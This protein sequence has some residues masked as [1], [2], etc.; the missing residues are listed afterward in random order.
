[1]AT[2]V[3]ALSTAAGSAW[4]APVLPTGGV[5][6]AGSASISST[7]S[8]LTVNQT[9]AKGVISWQGF[10][11]GQGGA[12]RINNGSG[13]T[14]NRVTG[15][16][17]SSIDGLLSA[18]GSVY[19]I[20]PNGIIIGKTGVVNTGGSFVASTLDV[21]NSSFLAGGPLGFTG[22]STA[23]VVNLG[24][25]G[26]LGG[27]IALI[28]TTVTNSGALT[29]ANGTVGLAAGS[30]VTL[31]DSANDD[32]GLLSVQLGG[33][34]SSVTTS[35]LIQ[36]AAAELRAQQGNIFALAGNTG[37]AIEATG[38]DGKGGRI[39]LVSQGGTASIAGTLDAQGAGAK[40][41]QIE[42]SG[43]TLDIGQ[44]S[45]NTH[46]GTWL[47]DPSDIT[48]T[49]AN[50]GTLEASLAT[51][52]VVEDTSTGSGGSGNITV[53]ALITWSSGFG[54]TLNAVGALAINAPITVAGAGQLTLNFN[55]AASATDGLSFGL[56][57]AGFAGSV[58]YAVGTG[59]GVSG[60]ALTINGQAYN[61][62]Y[63]M[64]DLAGISGAYAPAGNTTAYALA[65]PLTST[66]TYTSAVVSNFG[67]TLEGLGQTITGL[68]IVTSNTNAG[69][70]Q[71]LTG[72]GLVRDLGLVGGEVSGAVTV[73]ELV[74][75][76]NGT[77]ETSYATGAVSGA[78]NVGGLVGFQEGT[79]KTSYATGAVSGGSTVGGLLGINDAG[80]V[81]ASYATGAVSG[82]SSVGGLIGENGL[83]SVTASYAT[84]AVSGSDSVGG[85]IGSGLGDL[86]STSFAT[87]AVSGASNVGGLIG[88]DDGG[89]VSSSYWDTQTT[90]QSASADGGTGLTTA[91]FQSNSGGY[92]STLGAAFGGGTGGFF[93]YLAT[94]FPNGVQAVAGTL[95]AAPASQVGLYSGG[96]LLGQGTTSVGADGSY[97][98]AVPAGTFSTAGPNRVGDSLALPTTAGNGVTVA[99]VSALSYT[100]AAPVSG[101]I[102]L[103]PAFSAGTVR[104]TTGDS[105]YGQLQTDL[106]ITFGAGAMATLQT[107]LANAPVTVTS[108]HASGFTV[109]QSL[110]LANSL[111][112]ATTATGAPITV[113]APIT[114]TGSNSLTL[115]AADALNIDARINVTGG[116]Q[117]VLGFSTSPT[118]N[119]TGA[120]TGGLSF[121]LT[122]AGFTGSL[123]YAV[124]TGEGVSGQALT[125]NS[126]AYNLVYSMTDLAGIGG[127]YAPAGNTTAYAL[128]TPLTSTTTFT[129]PVVSSFSGKLEGL[130]QTITGL[131]INSGD[132]DVGLIGTVNS[133]GL[134]RDLGLVGGGVS[135]DV[136]VGALIGANAGT[137]ETSYATGTVS[138]TGDLGGLVGENLG[139]VSTSYATGAVSGSVGMGGLIGINGGPV[140]TSYATGAISGTETVGGLIGANVASGTVS[141]SYATGAV[142]GANFLGGLVGANQGAVLTSYATGPVSE[143]GNLGN[144][145][146]LVGD[147]GGTVS[148]SY[149]DTQ[150]TGQSASPEGGTGL[151]TAQFKSNSGS[152]MSNL[153]AAF[154]GG[155]GGLFPYL[156]AFFP[157][158][159]QAVAG[160]LS[161]AAASQVG[162]YSGGVLLG[163]GTT[164][165]GADGSYYL[166]VP[167]GTFSTAGPNR[168]GDSL[169]P[170][171]T[172]GNG[173]TVAAVSAL[174]YTDAATVSGGVLTL[175]AFTAGTVSETTGDASYSALQTD[176]AATFGAGALSTLQTALANTPV[177]LTSTNTG[178]F[179][180]DQ[181]VS[182]GGGFSLTA[183]GPLTLAAAGSIAAGSGADISL[184]TPGSFVNQ[185]GAAALTTSGGGNWL[186]YSANP[187]GDT[188]DGLNSNNTAVWNTAAGAP[189]TASGDRYVFALAPTLTLTATSDSK[190]YGQDDSADLQSHYT[191]TGLEPGVSGAYLG[192]T[193][194][195]VYS[196][197]PAISSTGSGQTAS[198]A[199]G[200]YAIVA[201]AG[202][203]AVQD[204]YALSIAAG[205]HL[206]VNPAPLTI[207]ADSGSV[208]YGSSRL[209]TLGASYIGLVAG[210]TPSKFIADLFVTILAGAYN[211]RA[212]SGSDV[213]SY[214]VVPDGGANSNYAIS[215]RF[216]SLTVT[217]AALTI[218]A[219]SSS[220]T[221]GASSLPVLGVS[222]SGLANGDTASS[223]ATAPTVATTATAYNG[224]AGSG[225]NAGR[226]AIT[227]SGAVDSN[228]TISYTPGSLT[229]NP[230]A[231]T[232][233]ANNASTTY[234][235]STLP[236]L[237]AS[238]T[239]LANGDTA[240]NLST[241][242]SLATTA[243]AYNG[244]AGSGSNAG[245]YAVT[246]SGA[247]DS[248]YAISYTPGSLTVNPAAL[249]IAANNASTTYGASTLPALSASYTG[250]AN[251][252]TPSNLSTAP[253]LATTATAY[254]GTAGSGSNAGTY[255]VTASGA[256]D[257]NYAISYTP[258]ALTV[259][260][261]SIT[262]AALGGIST[263]GASPANPGLSV[264]GL[265]NGDTTTALGGLSNSFGITSS[266]PAGAYVLTVLGALTDPNYTV[267]STSPGAW[268]VSAAAA[269]VGPI[270]TLTTV[271]G[272]LPETGGFTTLNG[273]VPGVTPQIG[274]LRLI[275]LAQTPDQTAP[276]C[277]SSSVGCP[278]APYPTN[279]QVGPGIRFVA[280]K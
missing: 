254:N 9:S 222:Y 194:A 67:G 245:T 44:A 41:G 81:S 40:P 20:N 157:N 169:A 154:G 118:S 103:L 161:A 200:P 59:E 37:G 246:A 175:P 95:S 52:N 144:L 83:G 193:A 125:I 139:A 110:T 104:E 135:G 131:T 32:G 189:V 237:S 190:T 195:A 160:T 106:A 204:G 77:V 2:S 134:V 152:Y 107:A 122:S 167:A 224:T 253:N 269:S 230:A 14:L 3:L 256:V 63:S 199:G 185:A 162:L 54:L 259:N 27:N 156:T 130:G 262:V 268:T 206:T 10:S 218:A 123:S 210:D 55:T 255:A 208:T 105:S 23:S 183:A 244:T 48:I 273:L 172:A 239:G 72:G 176:L 213:G 13:A 140:S 97:Y 272:V 7:A 276:A 198:V 108:A 136:G 29:A 184:S 264:A 101:G 223:L 66:T 102:L 220:M 209:P 61:L 166:A 34:A 159:V 145:G 90:G 15:A 263:S 120:Q 226:Y 164:S 94:F 279:L 228:Y 217:P 240:S 76:N 86:V 5:V 42:T 65:T 133:G 35:G 235:A 85:L 4:S 16:S 1:M 242:P 109:D 258:G 126:Q 25:V 197:A 24:K 236:A 99:A 87:G 178:G 84:G 174:S 71:E 129:D 46:G 211:G 117:V 80:S 196:G 265:Q 146:G 111:T 26:A 148:T 62:V 249:T 227:A 153:G 137:A 247:V 17:V 60:Q 127:A 28:A 45:V 114:L 143:S 64:A 78:S 132:D 82:G 119:T 47:L 207:T 241:A 171:T 39:W 267:A 11:I 277:A 36:A 219:S 261:A 280:S 177:V 53:N 21:A 275:S 18:T 49:S 163:Q 98:L 79:I 30:S 203:L 229:V 124:G 165:V 22:S 215:Y 56:T 149:W 205:G 141:T 231:L 225:S 214:T 173:V 12:V 93:P 6:T 192:D 278:G 202:T 221:Y 51:G 147:A 73:G 112:I 238:Y 188:F 270:P 232:I 170:P 248:N 251:G 128:A 257:S 180:V 8:T 121:G 252:D 57:S 74:A 88:A 70:I 31:T 33:P 43:Q 181:A 75:G 155:T 100:D 186:V 250:L 138:G 19:L 187:T 113:S 91:Q 92:M 234:G 201:A 260:R 116:G 271:A 233:A 212:G 58:S 191:I 69:L 179:T 274:L 115:N 89:T 96:V 68:T 151:T 142:S 182:A 216:G 150:T 158:G 38:V 243:T 168:V 266:T 50:V